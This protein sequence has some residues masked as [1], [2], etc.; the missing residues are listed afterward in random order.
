MNCA[1]LSSCVP[2]I[3]GCMSTRYIEHC[4]CILVRLVMESHYSDVDNGRD[5]VSNH[6]PHDCLPKRLF[7]RRSKKTSPVRGIY[8]WSMNSPHKWPVM[9]KMFSFDDVIMDD[10]LWIHSNAKMHTRAAS[11]RYSFGAWTVVFVE[12]T[13]KCIG[14]GESLLLI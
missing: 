11:K 13:S 2:E 5:G 6:Q 7:L 1:P 10:Y 8:R 12:Q 14:W 3:T 4:V 9:P